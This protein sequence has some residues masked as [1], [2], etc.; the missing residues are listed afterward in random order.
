MWEEIF[1]PRLARVIQ[2]AKAANPETLIFY[3]SDGNVWDAISGLI[4]AGVEVLNPVQPE[5]ID[6]AAAKDTFGDQLAFFGTISVQQTMPFG[7]PDDVRAEVKTRMQTIG[8]GGG[9]I[10]GPT[11][12]VQLDTPMDNFW[13]M[14]NTIKDTPYA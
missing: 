5:C 14:V 12:H 2:A 13:A 8:K 9:L 7:T 6:P 1:K 3:H 11:H 4:D 10:M